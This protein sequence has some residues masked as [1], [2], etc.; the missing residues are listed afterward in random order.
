LNT[1]NIYKP[2]LDRILVIA[3]KAI[4]GNEFSGRGLAQK[5][6]RLM[7]FHCQ[8]PKCTFSSSEIDFDTDYM[9]F[10]LT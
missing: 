1:V 7:H 9:S 8:E 10:S 6:Q 3:K 5:M 4:F 2:K